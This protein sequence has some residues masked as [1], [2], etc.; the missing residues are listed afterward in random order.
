[1]NVSEVM[2]KDVVTVE[3]GAPLKDVARILVERRISGIPVVEAGR[4]VGVV[5]DRDILHKEGLP[6][7][8]EEEGGLLKNL[9]HRGR[10][11]LEEAKR[12]A[13]TA[14]EAMTSPAI[15]IRPNASISEAARLMLERGVNRLPVVDD[16]N[17]FAEVEDGK[18][19][20]IVTHADLLRVFARPDEQIASEIEELLERE[21]VPPGQVSYQVQ[22]GE[23][24]LTGDVDWQ[25]SA[26]TL[27]AA[28]RRV[29]G[30]VTVDSRLSWREKAPTL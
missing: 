15:M 27:V 30:V 16:G 13:R 25:M 4:V 22:R 3:R 18:L 8:W 1:M 23:V 7:V 26:E 17:L 11:Q 28:I 24:I 5:T 20:G 9:F 14:G 29:P 2:T 6:E 19:V 12:E 10:E 21:S